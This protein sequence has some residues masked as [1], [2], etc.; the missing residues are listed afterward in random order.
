MHAS[1]FRW[2]IIVGYTDHNREISS[3]VRE[4][5]S[6]SESLMPLVAIAFRSP[7]NDSSA[8]GIEKSGG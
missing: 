7:S 2:P 8:T 5:Q 1:D 6:L 4:N 3:V